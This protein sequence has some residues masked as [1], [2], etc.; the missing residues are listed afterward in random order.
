MSEPK[1]YDMTSQRDLKRWFREMWGYMDKSNG[2]KGFISDGTD[3]EG[4]K[5]AL[6]GFL[7][8][9]ALLTREA[10][11]QPDAKQPTARQQNMQ[12]CNHRAGTSCLHPGLDDDDGVICLPGN[13][14]KV[15][16]APTSAEESEKR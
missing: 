15:H 7:D 8:L 16:K 4:R 5:H 6:Q 9:K 12:S 10:P 13:C 2:G 3:R 11:P 14:L 1:P